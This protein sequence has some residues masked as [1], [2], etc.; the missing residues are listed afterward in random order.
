MTP[1]NR[2]AP[3]KNHI[4]NDARNGELT[5]ILLSMR[6]LREGITSSRRADAFAVD[7][8]KQHI[9]AA[10]LVQQF[11]SYHAALKYL[12]YEIH[13][14]RPL[15]PQDLQEFAVYY[16]LHLAAKLEDY[17]DAFA[18]RAEFNVTDQRALQAVRAMIH[19][20]YWSYRAARKRVDQYMGRL[21]DFAEERVRKRML[22]C[23]GATY[24]TIEVGYLELVSGMSWARLVAECGVGWELDPATGTVTVKR[25]KLKSAPK[26]SGWVW[27]A[28]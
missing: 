16:V 10:I 6:K 9:R 26:P 15:S 24:F 14:Q 11:E 21:M 28:K 23:I 27:D 13:P 12:L 25:P 7:V 8:F 17:A 20:N 5:S 1:L 18:V 22:K 3:S 2:P 4:F 19:G